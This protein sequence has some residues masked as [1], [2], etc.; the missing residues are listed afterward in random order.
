[1]KITFITNDAEGGVASFILYLTKN[2]PIG[3]SIKLIVTQNISI[4]SNSQQVN[5]C[6]YNNIEFI[7][8]K[9]SKYDNKFYILKKLKKLICK[10]EV[11]IANDGIELEMFATQRLLNPLIFILHGDYDYYYD[12][13]ETY[14]NVIDKFVTINNGMSYI[15]KNLIPERKNDIIHLWPPVP[16]IS[17]KEK[18][19]YVNNLK[20]VFIGRITKEKGAFDLP[21]ID[22][23]L[24]ENGTQ[25][26]WF[27][28]GNGYLEEISQIWKNERVHYLGQINN[29]KL[30][31][32]LKMYDLIILPSRFE[33]LGLVIVEG[34]KA[35]LVPLTSNLETGVSEFIEDSKNGF[36]IDI[37]DFNSY[38]NRICLLDK[39]RELLEQIGKSARN[40][41]NKIFNPEINT[42]NY[43]AVF[44]QLKNKQSNKSRFIPIT[45]SRLDKKLI[46]NFLVIILRKL[47]NYNKS[48]LKIC[49]VL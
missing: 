37:L 27:I 49:V 19:N 45:F 38:V 21:I 15:L 43:Y 24:I 16:I 28:I 17:N 40:T 42:N 47:I 29:Q 26:E 35:G 39:N 18:Y 34:M 10:D 1:M 41:A 12:L 6:I 48:I 23:L 30:L 3:Y 8:F 13:A 36:L 2:I 25:V 22:N 5:E 32:T 4:K 46:P 31:D 20:I 14:K 11:I 33:S 9:Y 7:R 44:S